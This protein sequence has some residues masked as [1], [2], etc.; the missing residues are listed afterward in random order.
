MG[1][2]EIGKPLTFKQIFIKNFF[3]FFCLYLVMMLILTGVQTANV[4]QRFNKQNTYMTNSIKIRLV[5]TINDFK[6]N[7][8]LKQ[9]IIDEKTGNTR[10]SWSSLITSDEIIEACRYGE[11]TNAV[12]QEAVANDIGEYGCVYTQMGIYDLDKE[13]WI[14]K[15]G[16]SIIFNQ[17]VPSDDNLG[18]SNIIM[19][20]ALYLSDYLN[21][22]ERQELVEKLDQC[23]EGKRY[24]CKVEGACK[25]GEIIP[26]TLELYEVL[27][28]HK[29]ENRDWRK[30]S[31]SS[32]KKLIKT[33]H[34]ETTMT[35]DML[36]FTGFS[37]YYEG[38]KKLDEIRENKAAFKILETENK[39]LTSDIEHY[40]ADPYCSGISIEE[41]A[42]G[43]THAWREVVIV[44]VN[45]KRYGISLYM[46]YSPYLIA[47]HELSKIYLFS[48]GIIIIMV[49]VFSHQLW[50]TYQKQQE[51]EMSRRLLIDGVSHELKTP[52][53]LIRTYSEGIKENISEEKKT[54]YLE[55]I[56]DETYKM[57]QMVLDMLELSKLETN[58]K[59]LRKEQVNLAQLVAEEIAPKQKI[60]E[61]RK[62]CIKQVIDSSYI[63]IADE[64]KMR[65]VI[66]NLLMNAILHSFEHTKITISLIDNEFAIINEGEPIGEEEIKHIWQAFYKGDQGIIN[67]QKGTGLG[68][69]IVSEILKLHGYRYGVENR[70]EGVKFWIKF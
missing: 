47:T 38:N 14:A 10:E 54:H 53:S 16:N 2:K 57:D 62:L 13:S 41:D 45:G 6:Y 17:Y 58:D 32:N 7:G 42:A 31:E 55:V 48:L 8:P 70:E 69:A 24:F 50:R 65:Q 39:A 36:P 9:V 23:T 51:L 15:S 30:L 68:L 64:K 21:Q 44:T 5:E 28:G 27:I 18:Q 46:M 63:L 66:N 60:L 37:T 43:F 61:D 29:E 1:R 11:L 59:P 33:Y 25:N 52:L 19:R 67:Y 12:V 40:M 22:E 35:E 56:I 3:H 20:A 34:F 4:I 26:Q 49:I